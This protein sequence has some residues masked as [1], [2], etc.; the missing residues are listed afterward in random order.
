M[1]LNLGCGQNKQPGYVN[2][3]KYPTFDPDL[4][5]D[6]EKTPYPFEAGSVTEIMAT[7]VLEHLG[8]E[9]DVFLGIIQELHRL[10]VPGGTI[11]IKVPHFR[12][13]GYWGDPTHVRPVTPAILSLFSK[14]NCRMFKERGWPNTPLADYLDVDLEVESTNYA[15]LPPWSVSFDKG[16]ITPAELEEAMAMHWNVI[17]EITMT[18]RKV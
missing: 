13:D 8:R 9:T 10:L 3:D 6:L 4:V 2:I 16:E 14:K 18:V 7:H 5:W 17:D 11:E 15:L 12:G 1:K